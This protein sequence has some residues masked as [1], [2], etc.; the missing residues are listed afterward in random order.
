MSKIFELQ[1]FSFYAFDIS[2]LGRQDYESSVASS[3]EF[4][5]KDKKMDQKKKTQFKKSTLNGG[6]Q[7]PRFIAVAGTQSFQFASIVSL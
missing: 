2:H 7:K 5:F 6:G 1:D 4:N 3:L